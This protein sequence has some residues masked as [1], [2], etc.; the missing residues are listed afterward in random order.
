MAYNELIKN[1]NVIRD[2]IRGFYVYG[3]DS[4]EEY[5]RKSARTYDDA[6]RRAESY[7]SEY[8]QYRRNADGKRFFISVDT[9]STVHNP[10]YNA[11][12]AR[13]FT[14]GD[15]TLFFII[16][17]ILHD[18]TEGLP[19]GEIVG[20]IDRDYLSAFDSPKTFD[21]S[22]VRKKFNAFESL[23]CRRS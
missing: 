9:R 3:F 15:I 20:S 13:S 2:Y 7:L 6:K 22:T 12:K 8:M 1:F 5:D 10:L 16:F 17:D 23:A 21:V 4:R 19:L 11:L 14:D 18:S